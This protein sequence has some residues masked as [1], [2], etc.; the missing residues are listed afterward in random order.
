MTTPS[1]YWFDYETFGRSP[2]WDRPAQ[3]AGRRTDLE[4]NPIGEPEVFYCRL[5]G[6]YLPEPGACRITGITP[7]LVNQ[8]GLPEAH[9]IK[10]AVDQLGAPGTVSVGYNS[11]RFDDEFTRHTQFRNL[12]DAYAHEWRDGNSRWDLLDVVRLT[13]ALRPEGINWPVDEDGNAVNKLELLTAANGIEH[14]AAHDA[15]SDVD[16]T[17]GLARLLRTHQPRLFD[18]V[19][20][21]RSKS[22]AAELL[23]VRER[24]IV[25]LAASGIPRDRHH[26]AA[27]V[28]I[29]RHP[30]RANVV[31]AL[32]LHTAPE[33]LNELDADELRR[34]VFSRR[35]ELGTDERVGL[36]SIKINACPVL[37][38][39]T[40]L[41]DVDAERLGM[42]RSVLDTRRQNLLSILDTPLL[43][44]LESVMSREFEDGPDDPDGSLYSG[45]FFSDADKRRLDDI[46]SRSPEQLANLHPVFDDPRLAELLWRYRARNWPESLNAQETT[47]WQ[48]QV[49]ARLDDDRAPW[50]SWT[51]FD[52]AMAGEDWTDAE[53]SLRE[54]LQRYRDSLASWAIQGG[55]GK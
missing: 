7:T 35:D 47:R 55:Q 37:A 24:A 6:D 53:S 8:Q 4:L 39:I 42:D 22:A 1:F 18:Y 31:I 38:P 54:D 33:L 3:F 21:H 40:T 25:L 36:V 2:I 23:N 45:G 15:L 9:F 14:A 34:R 5:P 44:K 28:P 13:R 11:I 48:E 10:R 29:C 17:I 26:L 27:I 12:A 52:Q 50:S 20:K 30:S 51:A 43:E 16:A 41:G 19:F 49:R 46:R 32:D